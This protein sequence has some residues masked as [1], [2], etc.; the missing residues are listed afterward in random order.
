MQGEE[1]K[2]LLLQRFETELAAAAIYKAAIPC[3]SDVRQRRSWQRE[4][5]Q[6]ETHAGIVRQL[7]EHLHVDLD[8]ATPERLVIRGLGQS[9]VRAIDA[10]ISGDRP[11]ARS[12]AAECVALVGSAEC[13]TLV[14]RWEEHCLR[15]AH[16]WARDG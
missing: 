2:E 12:F 16:R 10:S 8:E 13:L 14:G 7:C 15:P 3:T 9:V 1:V 4:L 5:D 11:S 6:I